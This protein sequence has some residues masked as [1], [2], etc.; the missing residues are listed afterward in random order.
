M[1]SQVGVFGF[2]WPTSPSPGHQLNQPIFWLKIFPETRPK[3][4]SLKALE[5]LSSIS[6]AKIMDKKPI[7]CENFCTH[8][9]QP[10]I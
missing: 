9:P 4:A 1:T 3:S 8:K 7:I 5:W 10:G 2:F 6:I